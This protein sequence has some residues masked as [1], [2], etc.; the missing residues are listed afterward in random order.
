MEASS[1][2]DMAD[3]LVLKCTGN[4]FSVDVPAF[5]VQQVADTLKRAVADMD[6]FL[7]LKHR[8]IEQLGEPNIPMLDAAL[9]CMGPSSTVA[10]VV[11]C[12]HVLLG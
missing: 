3:T 8:A 11:A 10:D 12:Y 2:R 9:E 7:T 4:F 6:A 5:A 1:I